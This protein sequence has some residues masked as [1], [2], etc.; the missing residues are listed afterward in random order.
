[1]TVIN[2]KQV[3]FLQLEALAING[4][5]CDPQSADRPEKVA[6]VAFSLQSCLFENA[7]KAEFNISWRE[8]MK[9]HYA[10]A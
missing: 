9:C 1:M 5:H 8:S 3:Y 6:N 4:D 10:T 7:K 2:K